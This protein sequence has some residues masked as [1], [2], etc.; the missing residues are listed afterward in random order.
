MKLS[1]PV[2]WRACKC[3]IVGRSC[4]RIQLVTNISV[5]S[6]KYILFIQHPS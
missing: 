4:W 5:A 6:K 2:E 3:T 1:D